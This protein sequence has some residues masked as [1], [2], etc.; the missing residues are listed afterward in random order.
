MSGTTQA[1]SGAMNAHIQLQEI[2]ARN[3][4]NVD[5][6][7]FKRNIALMQAEA[8]QEQTQPTIEQ[9]EVDFSQGPLRPTNNQLDLAIR[10][11]GFFTIGTPQGL[12]YTRNGQ[13][14]LN[15]NRVLVT[16]NGSPVLSDNGEIRLPDTAETIRVSESGEVRVGDSMLGRLQITA[17]DNL[18][19]L[20]QAGSGEFID[21]GAAGPRPAVNARVEQ[22]FFEASNVRPIEE[23]V[24]MLASLRDFEA[25]ARSLRSIEDTAG[26]LYAWARA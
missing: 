16:Q 20:R 1:V 19:M 22:G 6:P 13:F 17:F 15:E 4:A 18:Q 25:S 2:A 10:G 14:C 11:D 7:G 23:M 3:V 24:R 12:R 21:E 5:T 26:K 9:V 8:G